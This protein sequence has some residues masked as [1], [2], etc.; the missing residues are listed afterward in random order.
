MIADAW[1][2]ELCSYVSDHQSFNTGRMLKRKLRIMASMHC[3]IDC[4]K[5]EITNLYIKPVI[6]VRQRTPM[7]L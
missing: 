4:L 5:A 1:I 6:A 7:T 2:K 3:C